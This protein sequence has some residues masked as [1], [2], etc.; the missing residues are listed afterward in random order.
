[1][2]LPEQ[3]QHRLDRSGCT[4]FRSV[5]IGRR[6]HVRLEDRLQYQFRRGLRHPVPDRRDAERPLGIPTWRA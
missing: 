1:M 5:A 2:A 3:S 6:V 4:A